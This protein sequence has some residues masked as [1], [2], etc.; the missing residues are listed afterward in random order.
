M[1]TS[2]R[3]WQ[4][5]SGSLSVRPSQWG[6]SSPHNSAKS[7]SQYRHMHFILSEA[8]L[9]SLTVP[10]YRQRGVIIFACRW[11]TDI[12]D[13]TAFA[14]STIQPACP[15]RCSGSQVAERPVSGLLQTEHTTIWD[16][17]NANSVSVRSQSGGSDD[18]VTLDLILEIPR[19]VKDNFAQIQQ[20][21]AGTY[22][23][24]SDGLL[25]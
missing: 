4:L 18:C 15:P 6:R 19:Y 14:L 9:L 13:S 1:E 3:L 23:S 24:D 22:Q 10:P 21:H 2:A 11:P 7:V 20:H 16:D 12:L 5:R 8:L 17:S 25:L